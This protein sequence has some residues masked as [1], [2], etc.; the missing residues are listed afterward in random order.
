MSI[1]RSLRWDEGRRENGQL[2]DGSSNGL[3]S[4]KGAYWELHFLHYLKRD[5]LSTW[6]TFG[7]SS[8][9]RSCFLC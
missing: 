7:S 8:P 1:Q 5:S 3:L 6:L 9:W 2:G 4:I